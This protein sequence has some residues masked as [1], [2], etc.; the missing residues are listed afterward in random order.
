M[1]ALL[2]LPLSL[3]IF[4]CMDILVHALNEDSDSELK[5]RI[6]AFAAM[7]DQICFL[8][9]QTLFRLSLLH[10]FSL[11]ICLVSLSC[12]QSNAFR[13]PLSFLFSLTLFSRLSLFSSVS[14]FSLVSLF[15]IQSNTFLLS[16][17]FLL[18]LTLFS[19]LSFLF[20]LTLFSCLTLLSSV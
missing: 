18:S 4:L 20:S 2:T 8:F 16:L 15:S 9:S 7:P 6:P 14:R 10:L 17:S 12:L 5:P 11:T 1:L 19:R 13:S 3:S